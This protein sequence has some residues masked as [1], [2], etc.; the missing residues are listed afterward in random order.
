M[1][2]SSPTTRATSSTATPVTRSRPTCST[3]G[4]PTARTP[5]SWCPCRTCPPGTSR[6][7]TRPTTTRSRSCAGDLQVN[8]VGVGPSGPAPTFVRATSGGGPALVHVGGGLRGALLV[9]VLQRRD[10]QRGIVEQA[11]DVVVQD[12]AGD[13]PVDPVASTLP[14]DD[15]RFRR[16]TVLD[17]VQGGARLQDPGHLGEGGPRVG[18]AAQDPGAQGG[19]EAVVGEG[20][21]LR[22]VPGHHH[23]N[24]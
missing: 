5:T 4:A 19:V 3:R 9:P 20:E 22:V 17:E 16:E 21:D 15:A 23:R 8:D 12:A 7:S 6:S 1:P 24:W 11:A 2:R 14:P 13:R 18:D 10:G